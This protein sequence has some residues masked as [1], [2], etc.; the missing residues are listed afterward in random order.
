[1][2]NKSLLKISIICFIFLS[3]TVNAQT[4]PCGNDYFTTVD[5]KYEFLD[6]DKICFI[7]ESVSHSGM[8]KRPTEYRKPKKLL[9][10]ISKENEEIILRKIKK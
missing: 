4:L 2:N 10:Q 3:L 8:D 6:K 5:G 7:V 9:F 1:M